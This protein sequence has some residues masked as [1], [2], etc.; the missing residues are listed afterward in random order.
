[1]RYILLFD[2]KGFI[3][4]CD[5]YIV[6]AQI[7]MEVCVSLSSNVIPSFCYST[8]NMMYLGIHRVHAVCRIKTYT[9]LNLQSFEQWPKSGQIA[10]NVTFFSK[11][12]KMCFR[13]WNFFQFLNNTC[14]SQKSSI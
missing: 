4:I 3:S 2:V 11:I 9:D 8:K 7:P 14:E 12:D 1:M 5:A 10:K 13:V 6:G